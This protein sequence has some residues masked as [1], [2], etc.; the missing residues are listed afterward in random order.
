MKLIRYE[1]PE[2]SNFLGD[3]DRVFRDA[4][5]GFPLLRG[6][7]GRG[8]LVRRASLIICHGALHR[9]LGMRIDEFGIRNS[10]FGMPPI[11]PGHF[12]SEE[13]QGSEVG[14]RNSEFGMP[15]IPPG[16]FASEE[17]RGSEAG[18]R[19]SEIGIFHHPPLRRRTAGRREYKFDVSGEPT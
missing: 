5:S 14:I 3:F 7:A 12:A 9:K 2:I 4:F 10:E 17:I 18:N 8:H 16:F 1:Q 19:N 11:S 13:I 15:P 6:A